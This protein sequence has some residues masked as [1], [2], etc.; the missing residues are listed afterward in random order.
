MGGF[1]AVVSNADCVNDLFYGTDYHSH[2]GT[3]RAGLAVLHSRGFSRSIHNIENAQFRSKFIDDISGMK[4]H[5]GIGC[6]SDTEGQPLIIG[7]HLG[8]F[9]IVTWSLRPN[10]RRLLAGQERRVGPRARGRQVSA[11]PADRRGM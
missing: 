11:A 10:I 5:L 4:G 2:L 9:A 1:F 7:S 8:T 3:R 6:I